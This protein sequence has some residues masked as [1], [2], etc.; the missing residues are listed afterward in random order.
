M[1][2]ARAAIVN[3]HVARVVFTDE[4]VLRA[5]G[6]FVRRVTM[7]RKFPPSAASSSSPCRKSSSV[8]AAKPRRLHRHFQQP[9]FVLD[10]CA[11]RSPAKSA[12]IRIGQRHPSTALSLNTV[13]PARLRQTRFTSATRPTGQS[14]AASPARCALMIVAAETIRARIGDPCARDP[15]AAAAI[16]TGCSAT[17]RSRAALG[18]VLPWH[19]S[20]QSAAACRVAIQPAPRPRR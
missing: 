11:Q 15:S 2:H 20:A 1:G 6:S 14:K 7:M 16:A 8:R 12:F 13:S 17:V 3:R 4:D 19:W 10:L 9:S 18:R 5:G